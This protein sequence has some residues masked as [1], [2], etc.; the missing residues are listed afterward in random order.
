MRGHDGEYRWFLGRAIPLRDDDGKILKWFGTCTDIH[1]QKM[2]SDVLE[3]KVV[4]RTMELQKSNAELED[5]NAELMQFASVASH[6]LKEPLRKIHMFSNIIKDRYIPETETAAHDYMNRIINSSAR[7]TK[8]I[9]DLLSYSRLS[10]DS[11]FEPTNFNRVIDEVLS[12]L[13][14]FIDE[15]NAKIKVDALPE[16]E[17]IPGQ[18]RQVFQNL[19]SNSLKF[20]RADVDPEIR[21]TGDLVEKAEVKAKPSAKGTFARI[22]LS[23]NGIGFD[24]QY[25]SKIFTI[26]QRL[27]SREKYEGTGIGLAITKKIIEKHRGHIFAEGKEGEGSTFIMIFPLKQQRS[28]LI[29]P[30]PAP[31][32]NKTAREV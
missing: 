22:I 31:K 14:L 26:F 8:L 20:S 24:K 23:D 11:F 17:A 18:V 30:T 29:A 5:T 32:K 16:I 6:D 28:N 4:E 21:I 9:N 25:S 10:V 15:K 19:I 13:E 2:M 12:D 27:H 7:M 1:D 3:Q